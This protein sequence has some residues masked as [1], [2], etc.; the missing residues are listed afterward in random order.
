[1]IWGYAGV[2]PGEFKV[3]DGD[4][5]MN[6]LRFLVEHGFRSTGAPLGELDD[7]A[8]RDEIGQFV[9][10]HD[11]ALTPHL[12][13]RGVP[14]R[15]FD[16]DVDAVRRAIDASVEA[17][18][19]HRDVVRAPIVTFGV[20]PYHRFMDSPSLDEQL[21]RLADVLPPA[22]AACHEMG[23]PLGIENH[24]DYYCDDLVELCRRVPHLG[25]FLDTG[26]TYLIGERSLP[27]CRAAAPYTIGTHF[28]DHVVHPNPKTLSFE[29]EGAAL[30]AGHVGLA[31][32]W[33]MLRRHAPA[34]EKLVMQW[35]LVPPKDMDPFECLEA[36][37][38]FIRSLPEVDA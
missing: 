20:G 34:A 23:C 33:D 31:D 22:A 9:A 27:A 25:I 30:G 15:F 3:W 26:N 17:I 28:K 24:G 29:I 36:S 6:T 18:R 37:W 1:M 21:D 38:A 7:P 32:I 8:R 5:T 13:V 2:W 4:R 11:L 19:R 12:G 35:E 16:P 10:E 14:G